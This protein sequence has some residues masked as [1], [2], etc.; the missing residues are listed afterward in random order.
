MCVVCIM[1]YCDYTD[2]PKLFKNTS[3]GNLELIDNIESKNKLIQIGQN[4]NQFVLDYN[5]K[6]ITFRAL[7]SKEY[8]ET[9]IIINNKI[10]QGHIEHYI[11]T[12]KKLVCIF[13]MNS[14]DEE[15]NIILEKGYIEYSPF[16]NL[17]Q[18]TYIKVLQ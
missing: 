16:Y 1:K 3:W 6:K 13:I 9:S 14:T 15:H 18:K 10:P 12:D 11:N 7:S 4:R 2:Y 8:N 17:D 5:I